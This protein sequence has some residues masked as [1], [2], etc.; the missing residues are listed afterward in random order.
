VTRVVV[1]ASVAVKWVL[2]DPARE[3]YT[4]QALGLLESIA[5]GRVQTVQPPHW[6]AEVA[7]V[8]S[9]LQ[10]T[11]AG[12]AAR[13]LHA[14]E[15]PVAD[16]PDVYV[17]AC[18]LATQLEHHVFDTLYHAVA[19]CDR[20]RMLITTDEHYLRKARPVGGIVH[21]REAQLQ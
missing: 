18:R 1:D 8:L 21:L 6:L 12:R 4:A 11:I 10:P 2:R 7:A 13:L 17:E 3:A 14:M 9:R 20:G 15:L 16:E 5:R 19:R